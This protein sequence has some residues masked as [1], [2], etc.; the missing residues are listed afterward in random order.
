MLRW[1]MFFNSTLGFVDAVILPSE[2]R[3]KVCTDLQWLRKKEQRNPRK[4][5]GNIPL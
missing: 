2:T 3:K 5:H 4:K 1:P